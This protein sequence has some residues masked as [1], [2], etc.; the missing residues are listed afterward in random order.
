M[1]PYGDLRLRSRPSQ[2]CFCQL[3]LGTHA[4][5]SIA[6]ASLPS[7]AAMS[8]SSWIFVDWVRCRLSSFLMGDIGCRWVRLWFQ[9][10]IP[11]GLAWVN[12]WMSHIKG[13]AWYHNLR[14]ESCQYLLPCLADPNTAG[15]VHNEWRTPPNCGN[16]PHH[17]AL[18]RTQTRPRLHWWNWYGLQPDRSPA[19]TLE[20][21]WHGLDHCEA[22]GAA[23]KA[24]LQDPWWIPHWSWHKQ[25]LHLPPRHDP[26]SHRWGQRSFSISK[27]SGDHWFSYTGQPRFR[28]D[29]WFHWYHHLPHSLGYL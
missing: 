8:R 22:Q 14:V 25:T 6:S 17:I 15:N 10:Q 11:M 2:D 1:A 19:P 12:W 21:S 24:F 3:L 16:H 23:Y 26:S 4:I 5:V 20:W 28:P 13:F 29:S 18:P 7:S 9:A 27:R